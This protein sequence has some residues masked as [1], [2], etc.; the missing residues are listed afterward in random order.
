[1]NGPLSASL[2]NPA[3]AA[4]FAAIITLVVRY[5]DHRISRKADYL[6]DY[7][8][9]MIFNGALAFFIVNTIVGPRMGLGM[10]Q[11]IMNGA[12]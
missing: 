8:K 3:S 1:M 5:I 12:F 4:F 10:G 7:M 2:R 6:M 11:S 9:A